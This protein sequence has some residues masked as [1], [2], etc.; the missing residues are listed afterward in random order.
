[1]NRQLT[2]AS[3]SPAKFS[4]RRC[5]QGGWKKGGGGGGGGIIFFP[6][7]AYAFKKSVSNGVGEIKRRSLYQFLITGS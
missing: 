2:G 3:P 4:T 5:R 7:L 1:M 6:G